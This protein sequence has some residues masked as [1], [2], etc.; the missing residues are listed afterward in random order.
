MKVVAEGFGSA[1]MLKFMPDIFV[2]TA[3]KLK[4]VGNSGGRHLAAFGGVTTPPDRTH[5]D[6]HFGDLIVPL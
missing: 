4:I 1:M 2:K 3:E 6:A 5:R